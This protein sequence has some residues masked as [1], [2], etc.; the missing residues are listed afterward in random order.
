MKRFIFSVFLLV[1]CVA[2]AIA[3]DPYPGLTII[4]E[5]TSNESFLIDLEYNVVKTWHGDE[6]PTDLAYMLPDSSVLRPCKVPNAGGRG[7]RIQKIDAN[8]VVVWDYLFAS[9]DHLQHHDIEP[10]P[11]GNVMLVA[12]ERKTL[13]EAIAAGR[14]I[15]DDDV[16]PTLIVEIEPDGPTGGNIVWEW[17]AW[18]HLI[19]D[20]DPTKDNYG[21][22]AD[23]PELLDINFS[24]VAT[25]TWMHVNAVDYNPELDQIVFS[26]R[27]MSEVYIIDHSTTTEEA[28]GHT[29]GNQGHGGDFLYR[30]GNPQVYGRGTE[31]DQIIFSGH[32]V[33]WVDH[34]LPGAGNL[35]IFNNGDRPGTIHDLSSV[36]EIL[37]PLLPD[38]NYLI[39]P[40]EAF[41]PE[42]PEWRYG[43][44]SGF[45]SRFFGGAYRMPNGNTLI[46]EGTEDF[47]FEVTA[48]GSVV[49]TFFASAEVHRAPR[50]WETITTVPE[51]L[52]GSAHLQSARP[53]PFNPVT[54]ITFVVDREQ[55]VMIEV[56]DLN[57]LRLAILAD[58]A[59]QPGLHTVKWGGTDTTGRPVPSGT[60]V[61]SMRTETRM[62]SRKITLVR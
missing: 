55:E 50:Y 41:G 34:G 31:D 44:V 26:S 56:F 1:A 52:A 33:N 11:N 47:I 12:W 27:E 54:S 51:P 59:Y 37:P 60:Y 20:A 53:N 4:S 2:T 17:H 10:M 38:G 13:A 61:V 45:F 5:R 48:A 25:G 28:A 18:D 24:D 15:V 22:I 19:Q 21:V 16:K 6:V 30:W 8:D 62:E 46:C 7:G 14:Q 39:T 35:L 29:G 9:D 58:R 32:G 23:H 49:W 42:Q 40:G 3:Q 43:D 36:E 57:G